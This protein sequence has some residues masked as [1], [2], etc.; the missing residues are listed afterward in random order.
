MSIAV[1]TPVTT[2]RVW[3]HFHCLSNLRALQQCQ[4]WTDPVAVLGGA[5]ALCKGG[6]PRTPARGHGEEGALASSASRGEEVLDPRE[7]WASPSS[8]RP[9]VSQLLGAAEDGAHPRLQ[10]PGA[11]WVKLWLLTW[12]AWPTTHLLR[13]QITMEEEGAMGQRLGSEPGLGQEEK[14]VT[15]HPKKLFLGTEL[16]ACIPPACVL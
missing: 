12:G 7:P 6:V 9:R 5:V 16:N 2:P 8:P 11:A 4:V 13:A 1:P 3:L 15:N 10:E 14:G